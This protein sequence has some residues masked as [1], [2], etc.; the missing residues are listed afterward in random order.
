MVFSDACANVDGWRFGE[1]AL[2]MFV[3]RSL[4]M[5]AQKPLKWL[6]D[7]LVFGSSKRTAK[8]RSKGRGE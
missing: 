8:P 5:P 1:A 2:E 6:S 7:Q 3:K 4:R